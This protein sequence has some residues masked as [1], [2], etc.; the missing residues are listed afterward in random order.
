MDIP[1]LNTPRLTLRPFTE[2][3]AEPLHRILNEDGLLRYFPRPDL[4][5]MARVQRLIDGQLRHWE[6]HGLGW[7]AV[8]LRATGELLGWNGLQYL[9]ETAEVEV[10]YLL[11]TQHWGQGLATEGA[12]AALRFGVD[13]L[14]LGSIVGIAHLEN[15]ASQRVLEK[16]G[17]M[18]VNEA[19]Y[20]GMHVRRYVA[21]AY[22][23]GDYSISTD[24]ARLDA[25]F[26]HDFL[27][28]SSYWA[29]GRPLA[30]VQRALE[31]SLCFGVY[32]GA[33]QVGLARV[34][35][36]YATFAWV[37]DVFIAEAHRG[38]GL[39]KWLIACVVTHPDLRDLKQI[40]L[41]TRDAH[42]LYRRYG[43]FDS[44]PTPEKWMI[45]RQKQVVGP[46]TPGG[47]DATR[48]NDPSR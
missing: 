40:L 35:T 48:A 46:A 6:E 24:P 11:S 27:A 37:C 33:E 43:G 10:G 5:D 17:L 16:S 36:D 47:S 22:R 2:A 14:G 12:Q 8:E 29:Q 13:T 26:V 25:G 7:W 15:V 45:R 39:G 21:V 1:A 34:V 28:N 41:A 3:D 18:F 9:P 42:E 4:P 32:R 20:F 23:H 31:S 30:V 44:L 19:D 38:H